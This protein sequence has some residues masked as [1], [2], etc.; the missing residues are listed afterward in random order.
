[1]DSLKGFAI[2]CV[3]IGHVADGYIEAGSF[4]GS[5]SIEFFVWQMLYAFHM[6]LFFIVSGFIFS[7][8]YGNPDGSVKTA[9]LRTQ[10]L[11]IAAVYIV[12]S[13]VLC[14]FKVLFS[15][16][17]NS[18]L[19]FGDLLGIWK[20]P[21][22][23]YWYLYVLAAFYILS[24]PLL[25]SERHTLVRIL[26]AAL[27]VS[28]V[29]GWVDLPYQFCIRQIAFLLVFFL[30]GVAVQRGYVKIS[31]PLALAGFGLSAFLFCVFYDSQTPPFAGAVRYRPFVNTIVAAGFSV[32]IFKAFSAFTWLDRPFLRLCGKYCL[33]IYVIHCYFT[34]G[35]RTLLP[36]AGVTAF[37]PNFILNIVLSTAFSLLIPIALGRIGL[38]DALFRPVHWLSKRR[39]TKRGG[40]SPAQH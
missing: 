28:L 33:G 7:V 9:K 20:L 13:A 17:V 26:M 6:P 24:A 37:W 8:A 25:K 36:I 3:V 27:S 2:L 1:M 35:F 12:F 31:M 29:S 38:H 19:G 23:P 11:D 10:L 4:P 16:H 14:A 5:L 18:P 30:F 22:S 15:G 21:I 40:Q 34:A 32:F 39:K